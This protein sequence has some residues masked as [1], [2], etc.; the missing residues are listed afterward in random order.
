VRAGGRT[1]QRRSQ[2]LRLAKSAGRGRGARVDA[3]LLDEL[4]DRRDPSPGAGAIGADIA[5][6]I[7]AV[8]VRAAVGGAVE[9]RTG[10]RGDLDAQAGGVESGWRD[11][12]KRRRVLHGECA[13]WMPV[14]STSCEL[15]EDPS[16]GARAI[17][18]E[19]ASARARERRRCEE[20][21]DKRG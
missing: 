19:M 17:S 16:P 1:R 4:R 14:F 7:G 2:H 13:S 12:S 9:E 3:R 15:V 11:V 6:A 21:A 5:R 8:I 20:C 10:E 18:A